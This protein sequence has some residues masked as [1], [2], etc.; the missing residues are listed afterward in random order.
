[1]PALKYIGDGRRF[2]PGWSIDAEAL[3]DASEEEAAALIATGLFALADGAQPQ[4]EPEPEP[5]GLRVDEGGFV[6][7]PEEAPADEPEL[8]QE[9]PPDG[10]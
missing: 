6:D 10:E 1:M 4:P 9:D 5:E 8:T 7:P 2:V 3:Q